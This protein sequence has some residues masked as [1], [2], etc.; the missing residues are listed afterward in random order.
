MNAKTFFVSVALTMML[1]LGSG[2]AYNKQDVRVDG[3]KGP[4]KEMT[5]DKSGGT[6]TI[7]VDP[8]F[9]MGLPKDKFIE[10][11]N[12][13]VVL[14]KM[15]GALIAELRSYRAAWHHVAA[16][17]TKTGE[18]YSGHVLYSGKMG[19]VAMG[20]PCGRYVAIVVEGLKNPDNNVA[21]VFGDTHA[22]HF[23]DL[24]GQ[25]VAFS[26]EEYVAGK[27]DAVGRVGTSIKEA[28]ALFNKSEFQNAIQTWSTYGI[29][30]A[31]S[32]QEW[33]LLV[34]YRPKDG[35]KDVVKEV[36]KLNPN[37]SVTDKTRES[38][39]GFGL[40]PDYIS[41]G[42][43]LVISAAKIPF[44]KGEMEDV[45]AD[46]IARMAERLDSESSACL[47]PIVPVPKD[48]SQHMGALER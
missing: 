13:T 24:Y 42:M 40:S 19:G 22:E 30:D 20:M 6:M 9:S 47:S 11:S 38:F 36:A 5:S 31:G 25:P 46:E 1:L 37:Y 28:P 45:G 8:V 17:N 33:E 44:I 10:G 15:P 48:V 39:R 35:E 21:I 34:P 14:A 3:L 32:G 23:F 4:V 7:P 41:T 27:W 12:Y 16:R 2:C 18:S 43:S 26:H 29:R